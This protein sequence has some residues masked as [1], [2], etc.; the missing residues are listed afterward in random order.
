MKEFGI[1]VALYQMFVE[2]LLIVLTVIYVVYGV[3][4]LMFWLTDH[5]KP[6]FI[7]VYNF[8]PSFI[9]YPVMPLRGA[10]WLCACMI[11]MVFISF[12]TASRKVSE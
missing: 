1:D 8:T 12:L 9:K 3:M 7:F 10:I 11:F 6:D 5:A 2:A 4:T